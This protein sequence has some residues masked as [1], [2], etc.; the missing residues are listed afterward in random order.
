LQ[1]LFYYKTC[2]Q[3]PFV[4]FIVHVDDFLAIRSFQ[5]SHMH[6]DMVTIAGTSVITTHMQDELAGGTQ[7]ILRRD[8]YLFQEHR[9]VMALVWPIKRKLEWLDTASVVRVA[10]IANINQ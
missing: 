10:Y 7:G 8:I 6:V 1:I 2:G 4:C 9:L 3:A 5:W